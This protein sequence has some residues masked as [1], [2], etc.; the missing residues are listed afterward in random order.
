LQPEEWTV[1]DH[2]WHEIEHLQM[3][4][5]APGIRLKAE[6]L[7]I[8]FELAHKNGWDEFTTTNH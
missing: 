6:Q 7:L 2:I 8:K 1:D 5:E 4:L 3:T